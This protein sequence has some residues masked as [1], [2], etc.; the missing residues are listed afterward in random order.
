MLQLIVVKVHDMCCREYKKKLGE[1]LKKLHVEYSL[2]RDL[3]KNH[4][5]VTGRSVEADLLLDIIGRTGKHAEILH[6]S[7]NYTR[8]KSNAYTNDTGKCP[9]D[10]GNHDQH[11]GNPC[12]NNNNNNNNNGHK[13]E[14]DEEEHK[15]EPYV[16]PEI[17]ARICRYF[18]C[19]HKCEP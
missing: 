5:S 10:T 7:R 8:S 13:F 9:H 1:E 6:F 11:Y 17:D 18:W 15:C 4:V 14:K 19:K 12:N 2:S 3:E 16:P